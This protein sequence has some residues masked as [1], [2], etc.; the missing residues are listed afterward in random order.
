MS[1]KRT[2][3]LAWAF[4][5]LTAC[6]AIALFVADLLSP[7]DTFSVFML[8]G[9]AL[10][11]LAMPMVCAIVAALIVSRQ[12]RNTIGW[13]LMM[14]PALVL[15]EGPIGAYL[16]RLAPSVPSPTLPVLL[17]AWFSSWSWLLLIFPLLHIPLLFPN[18][19][20]PTP[21]WRWVS[22]AALAWAALFILLVTFL[23]PLHA[24]T[25]P[26]LTLYNPIGFMIE[27]GD[28]AGV[29]IG[30]WILGLLTLV[31]LSVAALFVRYRRA[32][33][34]ERKQIK[35][36]LYACAVFLVICVGGAGAGLNDG[37]SLVADLW[38]VFFGLSL[39]AFPVAIGIAI[40][41]HRLYDIDII[42]RRTLVYST[43]TLILALIYVGCIVLLQ[44]L[45]VPLVGGS[46]LAIVASTLAIAT[47]FTPLRR[48]IQTLID[49]RFY[50]RK[51]DAAKVLAAFGVAARDETDLAQ[52]T[53]EMLRVVDQ[54]MQ[55]EFVGLWLKEAQSAER[56]A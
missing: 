10:T 51:Y 18:G 27:D 6:V 22:R 40:L 14:P 16:Q 32:N 43:L 56:K 25:T 33:E 5:G 48:R 47:L 7:H 44:Q 2:A 29:V 28:L 30:A 52:L 1:N 49:K 34:T 12:P 20:P 50:R 17:M 15:L 13:L 9:N 36:L 19:Q 21:R 45:V 39:G 11:A 55:P 23:Q 54:T 24:N 31:V 41:R 4:C 8:A 37:T 42:I 53:A 38:N 3:W 26:D 46:E 35:W